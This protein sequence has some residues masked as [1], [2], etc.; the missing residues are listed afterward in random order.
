MQN[1]VSHDSVPHHDAIHPHT[2]R[3]VSQIFLVGLLEPGSS[4]ARKLCVSPNES[5]WRS[6]IVSASKEALSLFRQRYFPT[7]TPPSSAVDQNMGIV[8][9]NVVSES[10][11]Q[12]EPYVSMA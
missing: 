3:L 11:T 4:L 5:E 12:F 8:S 1:S 2:E 7:E 10:L 6:G 9:G